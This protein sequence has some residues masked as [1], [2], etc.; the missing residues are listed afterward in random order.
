M[1]HN[2]RLKLLFICWNDVTGKLL[3]MIQNQTSV[4]GPMTKGKKEPLVF[5]QSFHV[6]N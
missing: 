1:N 2:L 4:I 3:V 6:Q 5:P